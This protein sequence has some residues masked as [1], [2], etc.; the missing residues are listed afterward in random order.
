MLKRIIN[1]YK[2]LSTNKLSILLLVFWAFISRGFGVIREALTGR[3]DVISSDILNS[4]SILNETLVTVFIIGGIGIVSLP[5]IS[6]I[7]FQDLIHELPEKDKEEIK[8]R[9]EERVNIY[10]SWIMLLLSSLITLFSL[11]GIIFS[12]DILFILNQDFFNKVNSLGRLNEYVLLN[13]IFLVAPV[14]FGIKTI[15]GVFL[16]F[17][18]AFKFYSL[19]GVLAN[20]G[21]IIGLSLFYYYFG[22]I[23]AGLGL[24]LGFSLMVIALTYDSYIHGFKFEL[25]SF[26]DLKKHLLT[27][28]YLILP[29]LILI[30]SPR[31]AEIAISVFND[32]LGSLSTTRMSLNV[33]G[34]FYGLMVAVGT[35]M[36]PDLTK[37]LHTKGKNIEFWH[38]INKYLKNAL[39][40]SSFATIITIILAPVVLTLIKTLSYANQ[41]SWIIDDF[42]FWQTIF[43]IFIGSLAIIPQALG[44]ILNRYYIAIEDNK[45]A[46]ITNTV[47]NILSIVLTFGILNITTLNSAYAV[48]I[49]FVFNCFISTG[50]MYF[51]LKKGF[52]NEKEIS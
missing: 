38:L 22:L 12:K 51:Y 44:E 25:K 23:G 2:N 28:L 34:V 33:Q 5:I 43:L 47:G 45:T 6:K 1:K 4:A 39:L 11:I 19:D 3:L 41:S 14:I 7:S 37:I 17:K 20:I 46:I 49:G 42:Y 52:E 35:V 18:K 30:S 48:I 36:L 32:S 29:R 10:I 13:Q 9:N 24:I 31:I 8:K 50:L 26:P 40:I 15:F 21:S 16:N 27:T